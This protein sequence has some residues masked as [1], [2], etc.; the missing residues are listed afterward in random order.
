MPEMPEV[1]AQAERMNTALA[2]TTFA[3]FEL[4]NF[5]A[6]KTF[7][8]AA[9]LSVGS[10]VESVGRRGKYLLVNF[11]DEVTHVVHL[12]QGG[13]WR[14]DSKRAKKLKFGLARW[15][16]DNKGSS[17]QAWLLTEAGSER[18]AG[19]WAVRGDPLA[20]DPILGLGPEADSLGVEELGDLIRNHSKRLHGLLRNQRTI[21]GLGRML[22]NE[23]LFEAGIS[24]FA[25]A[26]KLDDD[27]VEHLH[28]AITTVV[29]R[30]TD[31]ERTLDGIGKSADRPSKVHNRSG[32]NCIDCNDTVR[33]V[34][35]RKYTVF[36]CPTHQTNGKLLADNTTSKFL[37]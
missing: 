30:A 20:Q 37:K 25:N 32:E 12:M 19:M 14:L 26:A 6:L 15:T 1:Q 34:E 7:D 21:A 3:R 8:P 29:A 23:I 2:G 28:R 13:R 10:T 16:F 5:A 18:K 22:T 35:Y 27:K 24:P 31:H 11:D 36:Y 33:T 4:L 9:D 17:D